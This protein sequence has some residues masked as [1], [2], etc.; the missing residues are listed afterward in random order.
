MS[1]YDQAEYERQQRLRAEYNRLVD[2]FNRLA[3][4]HDQ[5]VVE[6]SNCQRD[7]AASIEIVDKLNK[8]IPPPLDMNTEETIKK[9]VIA[10]NVSRTIDD[11][12][13]S[14]KRL[15]T[16]STASKNLTGSYDKYYTLYGT[17]NELRKVTLGYVVGLDSNLWTS[18]A[19]RAKVEKMYLANTDYWLAY[20]TMA[21]M[22]WASDEREACERA[23]SKSM[24]M[25]ERKSALFFLLASL[26]FDKID[27]A[28]EWYKVY[29]KLVDE[30]GVGDEIIYIL[31]TLLSGALG[32]DPDFANEVG[33]KMRGLI[34]AARGQSATSQLVAE[35]VD[36]HINA[37]ISVTDK[38]FI[39][40]KHICTE[41]DEMLELVSS[42]EKNEM[43]KNYFLS[44]I[45]SDF[46]L[47]DR[48]AERIED[49]LYSLIST[50]DDSEQ[51][52][53]DK[54]AY[55]E[56]VV[57]A[58]GRV[59]VAQEAYK[60]MMEERDNKNN[61]ALIMTDAALDSK[62]KT[63]CRVRKFCLNSIR[64]D[65]IEGVKRFGR[66]RNKEKKVYSLNVD[67]CPL[68][69]DE[70]SFEELKPKLLTYY[71]GLVK[72]SVRNDKTHNTCGKVL[73]G[74]AAAFALFLILCVVGFIAG[75][76]TGSNV[77]LM[78]LAIVA[79]G[80][81]VLMVFMRIDQ[82]G[83]IKKAFRYR[84][85][86]GVKMLEKGLEDMA[87]WRQYYK[88]QDAI[89]EELMRVLKEEV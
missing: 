27:A 66:Y 11:L 30:G 57:K 48:L 87:H 50:Y 65:C 28:K 73:L 9:E 19:P 72:Q 18:D 13:E 38:E 4:I 33:E 77:T 89:Y 12:V 23:V 52:L 63:D 22:L 36:N 62:M 42:A 86:N 85:D 6:V 10:S 53:M 32:S 74:S 80:V 3:V 14:Y 41:Y 26:R 79:L 25:N 46:S 43:L 88:E 45:Q 5:L 2:E 51:A 24:Q 40:L 17:Y 71:D 29:F 60:K 69:G 49:S 31:Q 34:L 64:E 81:S 55:E 16:G 56:A 54:I 61:L 67:G 70:N 37:L 15:K 76:D 20:A 44:I 82:K 75:W 84:I 47:S 8:I 21:V 83:K 59:D 7:V 35:S 39:A 58:N 1:D 78:V 68:S